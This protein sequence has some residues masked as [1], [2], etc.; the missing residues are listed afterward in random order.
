MRLSPCRFN[1]P[2]TDNEG[3]PIDPQVIVDL[4]RE[5]LGHFGG[6]TIHPT[7][8]GR[9]QSREGRVYEEEVLVY[10][11]AAPKAKVASLREIASQLGQR[12]GQLAMYFDAPA[13]SVEI[14]ELPGAHATTAAPAEGSS[15]GPKPDNK[16]R[17]RGKGD[18]P[19][20]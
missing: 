12:L 13:P 20:S 4:H 15:D 18:R 5:L 10:E 7:S 1:A 16:T 11:V 2:L 6:F 19:S 8:E 14:I 9:W 17:R 3:R